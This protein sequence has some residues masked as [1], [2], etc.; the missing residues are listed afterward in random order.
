MR[1]GI[2]I[3][4]D[5]LHDLQNEILQQLLANLVIHSITFI[6]PA[7][8]S[9][10]PK[11]RQKNYWKVIVFGHDRTCI[12]TRSTMATNLDI[13]PIIQEGVQQ[14]LLHKEQLKYK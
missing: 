7:I 14:T 12:Y 2:Q 10:T 8:S 6:K 5:F 3:L 13:S 1:I 4:S 9:F 11:A